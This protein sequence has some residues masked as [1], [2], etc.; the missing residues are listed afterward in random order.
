[1]LPVCPFGVTITSLRS[2][3]GRRVPLPPLPDLSPRGPD[4]LTDNRRGPDR[5]TRCL[6]QTNQSCLARGQTDVIG[7]A[8]TTRSLSLARGRTMRGQTIVV[9]CATGLCGEPGRGGRGDHPGPASALHEADPKGVRAGVVFTTLGTIH[10]AC[11]CVTR[12]S[13]ALC[14]DVV[15]NQPNGPI[16]GSCPGPIADTPSLLVPYSCASGL[17][18]LL[19]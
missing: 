8:K 4:M 9:R 13:W 5:T 14:V 1:M 15:P 17:S 12:Y 18:M 7:C 11:A 16:P 6:R 3:Q 10:C 2:G 19:T